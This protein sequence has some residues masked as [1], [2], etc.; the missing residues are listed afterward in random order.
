MTM[1]T[2]TA[3]DYDRA[4]ELWP[5]ALMGMMRNVSVQARWIGQQD[6]FWFRDETA[7]GP[8]FV[9][10]DAETGERGPL[11]DHAL[12]ARALKADPAALPF[13]ELELSDDGGTMDVVLPGGRQRIDLSTGAATPL[14][15]RNPAEMQL[16]DG[17]ALIARQ[18]DLWLRELD[19][20]ERRLTTDGAPAHAWAVMGEMDLMSVARSRG[21]VGKPLVG[22]F[23]SPDLTRVL[24]LRIDER[25]VEPY[26]YLESVPA[27][28]SHRPKVHWVRQ[29]LSGEAAASVPQWSVIDLASGARVPV[30]MPAEWPRLELTGASTGCA[31][32]RADSRCIHAV[33]QTPNMDAMAVLE[34]DA[35]SGAVR[36]LHIEQ[37]ETFTDL[38]TLLYQRPIAR[39]LPGR[40]ELLWYSQESGWGHLYTVDLVNGGIR[41]QVTAGDWAVLDIVAVHG[42]TVYFTAGGREPGRHPYHRHLYRASLDGK[43]PN[44]SLQLLTPEDADHALGGGPLP[45]MMLL[46]GAKAYPSPVSPSGRYFVDSVSTVTQP[47]L[48]LLRRT[49]GTLVSEVARA[50]ISAL[51]ASGWQPPEPFSAKA[52]DG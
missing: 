23:P 12:V 26:P 11:F 49:D 9:Q 10:V 17:R 13:T 32:W 5:T 7:T 1:T 36:V 34:V 19:G 24:T 6:R 37:A 21:L 41:R 31:W 14:P 39:P 2:L 43:A 46:L 4:L 20:T 44:T 25:E 22:C 27:D 50:D 15:P 47:T 45:V 8:R 30:Q 38:N 29:Q 16:T 18:H 52:A 48:T 40:D 3:T 51:R 42:D 33:A 28:G 35:A